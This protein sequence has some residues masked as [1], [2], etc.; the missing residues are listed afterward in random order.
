MSTVEGRGVQSVEVGARILHAMVEIGAAAMLRDI[1]A[2]ADIASAQAHAYLVSFRKTGLVEQDP[3]SG[4]YLLG[5]F[6]LQLGLARMRQVDTLRVAASAAADLATEFGLMVTLSVWGTHGPTIVQ[7]QEAEVP[8]HVNLRAGGVYTL[9]G[10][11]TGR[12]FAAYLPPRIVEP[13]VEAELRSGL[14][15][16][17]IGVPTS[18]P[19]LAKAAARIRVEGCSTTAGSPV[20]GINAIA[21]PIFDHTGQLQCAL[22]L[23]GPE[24]E[25]DISES[26]PAVARA[27]TFGREISAK[28]GYAADRAEAAPA[29][30][31]LA[32]GGG[33]PRRAARAEG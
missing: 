19:A 6:A 33:R 9:T 29:G 28:L 11:A 18:L 26:S 32:A 5:P 31:P 20:P 27:R 21:V 15:S 8:I 22:T 25:V 3:Q 12:L 16:R 23:I 4:R 24:N 17:G 2:R 14:Q 1:A 30:A 13:L 10:T 7:V